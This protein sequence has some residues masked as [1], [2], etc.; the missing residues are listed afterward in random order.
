[1]N[2]KPLLKIRVTK[3]YMFWTCES[4]YTAIVGEAFDKK[5]AYNHWAHINKESLAR[6]NAWQNHYANTA[7]N[8]IS[9]GFPLV[10]IQ[11]TTGK[12]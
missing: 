4:P 1:M 10:P 8:G 5:T 7:N 2:I 3:N 6:L 9:L 12:I 11:K